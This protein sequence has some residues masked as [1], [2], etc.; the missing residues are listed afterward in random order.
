MYQAH[1]RREY[2][3]Q[4]TAPLC[5][6]FVMLHVRYLDVRHIVDKIRAISNTEDN[7]DLEAEFVRDHVV[8]IV[9]KDGWWDTYFL[10]RFEENEGYGEDTYKGDLS[11]YRALARCLMGKFDGLVR[12]E[13][14]GGERRHGDDCPVQVMDMMRILSTATLEAFGSI[15]STSLHLR[16]TVDPT[17]K[18]EES[19]L[20]YVPFVSINVV[21]VEEFELLIDRRTAEVYLVR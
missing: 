6:E 5:S 19:R 18:L 2:T 11:D 13:I 9:A 8:G 3:Q 14:G 16:V 17:S 12:S 20:Q 21:V 15:Y 1:F 4:L 7:S 10:L